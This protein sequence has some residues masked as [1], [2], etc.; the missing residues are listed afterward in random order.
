MGKYQQ[1]NIAELH[2]NFCFFA[3]HFVNE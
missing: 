1:A 2:L 3:A